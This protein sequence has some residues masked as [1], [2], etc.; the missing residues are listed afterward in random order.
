MTTPSEPCK[1]VKLV[2]PAG[3]LTAPPCVMTVL[4]LPEATAPC[5]NKRARLA[6]LDAFRLALMLIL[7]WALRVS[8]L[9]DHD[10]TSFTF[11]SPRPVVVLTVPAVLRMVTPV[12]SKLLVSAAPVMSPPL[13][14]MVKSIG[15]ISQVPLLPLG[16]AVVI[17][18][19]SATFT[20]AAEVSMKPPL[21]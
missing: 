16:A 18:A 21:L 11:T 2:V 1:V 4:V 14:A 20:C 8:V 19:V 10:T 13:A 9:A 3:R 12:V 15:S 5:P 7:F 17:W 6:E